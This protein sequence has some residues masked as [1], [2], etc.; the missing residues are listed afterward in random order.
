LDT[1]GQALT[2]ALK[3]GVF[4]IKPSLRELKIFAGNDLEH[5]ADQEKAAMQIIA[6]GG[7]KAVVVSLGSAGALLASSSGCMR[8]R[9]LT[10]PVRSKVGAGDSMVAGIALGLARGLSL[11]KAV[12]FGVAA[13]A[14]AV[15]NPG[16]ELCHRKDAERLFKLLT[17]KR[18][19]Q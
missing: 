15:M 12:Q 6:K 18:K 19:R 1:S 11:H 17:T 8:I 10:V 7:A 9:S 5:E 14:A 13:G 2:A 3:A 16:T 4:L